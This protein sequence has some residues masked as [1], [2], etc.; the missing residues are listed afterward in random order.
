MTE[1]SHPTRPVSAP[2]AVTAGS[3][4]FDWNDALVGAGS[5]V[6]AMLLSAAAIAGIRRGR[7]RLVQS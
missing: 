2:A 3:D 4:G 7:G 6:A 1:F 5:A